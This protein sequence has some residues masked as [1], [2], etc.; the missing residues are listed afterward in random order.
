MYAYLREAVKLHVVKITATEQ[1]H[2]LDRSVTSS[3]SSLLIVGSS[4]VCLPV[5]TVCHRRKHYKLCANMTLLAP[6]LV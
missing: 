4:N 2:Y 3:A 6:T 1:L 5:T